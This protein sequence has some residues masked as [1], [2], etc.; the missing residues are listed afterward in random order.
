MTLNSFYAEINRMVPLLLD[1]ARGLTANHISDNC[2]F[3]LSEISDLPIDAHER[4]KV[5]KQQN[6]AK[7]PVP[8]SA[9]MPALCQLYPN[10]HDVNLFIYHATCDRTII[11]IRY[12][13][14]TS[15]SKV[16]RQQVAANP[17]MLHCKVATPPWLSLAT[18]T[19][20]FDINWERRIGRAKWKMFWFRYGLMR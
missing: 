5:I 12:Y 6:E 8:L 15:L 20:K 3:I 13:P 19:R 9:L 10:L 7:R 1:M 2:E 14:R 4:R 17:P 16:H 11:D 18:K